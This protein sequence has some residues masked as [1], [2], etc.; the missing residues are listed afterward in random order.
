MWQALARRT[1]AR[2]TAQLNRLRFFQEHEAQ[3][4]QL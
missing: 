4:A 2:P 1:L 3:L